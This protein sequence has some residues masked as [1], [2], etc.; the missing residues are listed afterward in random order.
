MRVKCTEYHVTYGAFDYFQIELMP[1]E[2]CVRQHLSMC[3]LLVYVSDLGHFA[4]K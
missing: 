2:L 1:V 4:K 3:Q